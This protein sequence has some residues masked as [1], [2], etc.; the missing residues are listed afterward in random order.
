MITWLNCHRDKWPKYLLAQGT[1]DHPARF[2]RGLIGR[3]YKHGQDMQWFNPGDIVLD[4]FGGV[5]LGAFD[6]MLKGLF[7]V[8]IDIDPQSVQVGQQN[9]ELWC[10]KFRLPYGE[11][12][13]AARFYPGDSRQ[14]ANLLQDWGFVDIVPCFDLIISSPPY[15]GTLASDDPAKRGGLFKDPRRK[16]DRTLTAEYSRQEGQL[17]RMDHDAFWQA[18]I[19]ILAQCYQLLKRGKLAAWVLRDFVRDGKR[20]N[21]PD[22]WEN[23]CTLAG[24]S[25]IG[26]IHA[27]LQTHHGTQLGLLKGFT[28]MLSKNYKSFFRNLQEQRGSPSIDEDIILVVRKE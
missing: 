28:K 25:P 18:S 9:I 20:Y 3:L 22:R 8:G 12:Y 2:P 6:A 14:A 5:A 7:W 17:G 4:P 15:L 13:G 26:H 11:A 27:P 16:N 23:A 1:F 10:N 21:F 24:F 19:D